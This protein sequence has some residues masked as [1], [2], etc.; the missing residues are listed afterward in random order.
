MRDDMEYRFATIENKMCVS[1]E[2]L[3][4]TMGVPFETALNTIKKGLD[5]FRKSSESWAHFSDPADMRRKWI[6]VDNL[7]PVTKE[8]FYH[9]YGDIVALYWRERM[10]DEAMKMVMPAD[11]R[12]FMDVTPGKVKALSDTEVAHLS[13]GCGWMRLGLSDFWNGKFKRR[14]LFLD[15]CAKVIHSR[16]LYGLKLKNG[17]GLQQRLERWQAEGYASMLP[18]YFGNEAAKKLNEQMVARIIDLYGSP[19]KPTVAVV[20]DIIQAEA[21]Q[22]GWTPVT[23]ERIRQVLRMSE[24]AQTCNLARHGRDAAKQLQEHNLRR[25]RP[26]YADA[27]WVVD[28]STIQL[29]YLEDGK[30]R[31]DLYGVA[32]A[33]AY[34]R[35][36]IGYAI[37][38]TETSTLVQTALRNAARTTGMM[39]AQIQYDNSSANKA[40]E[41]RQVM[42]VLARTHFPTAPYN[43]KSKII[44][45]VWGR[46]EQSILHAFPNFKGGNI[47]ARSLDSRA[48]PD[49]LA[50]LKRAGQLP[51]KEQAIAQFR[52]AIETVNNTSARKTRKT[53]TEIYRTAD[54]RRCA[55]SDEVMIKAFWVT[56][57]NTARYTNDGLTIEVNGER[58]TYV[59]EES[60]GVESVEWRLKYLGE[61][62]TVKYDPE[63]MSM[64]GLLDGNG[65][66]VGTAT[67]K[68]EFSMTKTDAPEEEGKILY[69]ALEARNR[70]WEVVQARRDD[71]EADMRVMGF[72]AINY[73]MI[74]KDALN[75]M[76]GAALDKLL[77][78][79][80][81][82]PAKKDK[83]T[84]QPRRVQLY[85]DSDADGSIIY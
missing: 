78:D 9:Y 18:G 22:R 80:A 6:I 66:Y 71:V 58:Y 52:L 41:T 53:P 70:Y 31:S 28:G 24:N 5:R 57:R 73:R 16:R 65:V 67:K 49:Y 36:I 30:V 43:G 21:V 23:A 10:T 74:H 40:A 56:R 15:A 83:V 11:M 55:I 72:E 32:I 68:Y 69:G 33:D 76:E 82:V 27:L 37:G 42:D 44:E 81:I 35:A 77:E 38:Y 12:Y 7:P 25:A 14:S 17:R 13:E 48:N 2:G 84:E 64:I 61:S 29:Y 62:F 19:I 50:E 45:A 47:T 59:V 79:A 51:S 63:D 8:R 39:P 34:S 46:M 75:R 60:Q 54:D 4:E 26:A 85:D 20:A 1:V 3:A